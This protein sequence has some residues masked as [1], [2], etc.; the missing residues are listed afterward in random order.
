ML[1]TCVKDLDPPSSDPDQSL[2]RAAWRRMNAFAAKLTSSH[3]VDYA[4]YAIW[5]LR[6]A[7]EDDCTGEDLNGWLPAAAEW[8]FHAGEHLLSLTMV[9]ESGQREGDPARGGQR[10]HGESGFCIERFIIWQKRFGALASETGVET[11][12]DASGIMKKLLTNLAMLSSANAS[13]SAL[14]P[15][16]V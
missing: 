6:E 9:Y 12:K 13:Y 5:T 3:T 16:S 1:L 10:W 15:F 11:A 2:K 4:L 7:L 14:F 8:I